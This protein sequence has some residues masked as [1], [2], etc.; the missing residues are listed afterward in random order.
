MALAMISDGVIL[1]F[2]KPGKTRE[3]ILKETQKG[4]SNVDRYDLSWQYRNPMKLMVGKTWGR[5]K[6]VW[7][8]DQC[9]KI[10][11]GRTFVLKGI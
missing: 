5:E 4:G 7:V 10:S 1:G 6:T 9:K 2:R 11:N 3:L 8:R